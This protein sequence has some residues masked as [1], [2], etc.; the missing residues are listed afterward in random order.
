MRLEIATWIVRFAG[1]YLAAGVLFAVDFVARG[2][3]RIDP[4][5]RGAGWGFRA[6]IFPGSCL[7]WPL[8]LKRRLAGRTEP[9]EERN[10]HRDAAAR[11][12]R[13]RARVVPP[14]GRGGVGD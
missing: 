9:S 14:P 4:A 5:A 6:L 2:V 8:L 10:A 13:P 1:V 7:F 3:D 11:N 12:P